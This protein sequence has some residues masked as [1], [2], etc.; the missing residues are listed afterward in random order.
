[1]ISKIKQNNNLNKL[2]IKYKKK[3][4]RNINN[5]WMKQKKQENLFWIN[6]QK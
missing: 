5:Y 1:M 3:S 6:K 4:I 2:K